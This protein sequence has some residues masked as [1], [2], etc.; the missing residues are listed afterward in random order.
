MPKARLHFEGD[1]T[2]IE[3]EARLYS[4]TQEVEDKLDSI[5]SIETTLQW[6]IDDLQDQI[7]Q[8]ASRGRYLTTWDCTTWLPD[9]NPTTDPYTYR[10]WDYYI[11]GTVGWTNYRPHGSEYHVWVASQTLET[12]AV[13]VNDLY[14]YDWTQWTLQRTWASVYAV[15]WSI[16]WTLS[17]QT[18]LQNALNDKA[19]RTDVLEKTNT[20]SY[21][22]TA[23]YHP[24]TKKY[25]DD[26]D[27]YIW[28]SAPTNNVV[29]W[30]LWY[31]TTADVLKVYDWSQWVPTGKTYTA[32]SHINISNADVISTTGLQDELTAWSNI[33]IQDI[34]VTESDMKWPCPSGFHVPTQ[35]ELSSMVNTLS[36]FSMLSYINTETYY[37]LPPIRYYVNGQ[38]SERRTNNGNYWS[39]VAYGVWSTWNTF[40]NA[41]SLVIS[42]AYWWY[43]GVSDYA[44]YYCNPIRP[45]K[46]TSVAP[47]SNW[48]ILYDWSAIATGAG[49]FHNAAE[50]LISYSSDWTTWY[51]IADK[52]LWATQVWNYWDAMS[53]TNCWWV[54]QRWNNYMFPYGWPASLSATQVDASWY[55]PWNYYYSDTCIFSDLNES[56][57]YT[58]QTRNLWW[59]QTQSTWQDCDLTISATDTTYSA[60]DFDIKDLTDSTGLRT[61]WNSKQDALTAWSHINI[62]SNVISTTGLQDKLTAWDNIQI[63]PRMEPDTKWPCPSWFHV[64]LSTELQTLLDYFTGLGLSWNTDFGTYLKMPIAWFRKYWDS[65]VQGQWSEWRYRAADVYGNWNNYG[66]YMRHNTSGDLYV[67]YSN[68]TSANS[69]RAFKNS[70][71]IP[72]ASWTVLY[73]GSSIAAWAWIFHNATEWLISISSDG[74]NWLTIADKN[75]GATA[76]Y[77]RWDQLSQSN[78][79]CYYQRWNNYWFPFAWGVTTSSTQVDASNYWPW[80]YYSS[81]IFILQSYRWFETANHNLWWWVTQWTFQDGDKISA[82]VPE[83]PNTK[84]FIVDPTVF[85]PDIQDAYDWYAAWNNPILLYRDETYY[86]ESVSSGSPTMMYFR[87]KFISGA[88]SNSSWTQLTWHLIYVEVTNWSVTDVTFST[89]AE[90][91]RKF[92]ATDINYP[93]PYTPQYNGSP[94]TK[95]YVD[96]HWANIPVYYYLGDFNSDITFN[97]IE[98]WVYRIYVRAYHGTT[99]DK[100]LTLTVDWVAVGAL[101]SNLIE[102]LNASINFTASAWSTAVLSVSSK[103]NFT[104]QEVYIEKV[105]IQSGYL[106][107]TVN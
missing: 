50:W 47:D 6:E 91:W 71:V 41:W 65:G 66:Y 57:D 77:N 35:N 46:N 55:W 88:T 45:F 39:S 64:P 42:H 63:E 10:P 84:T 15:W 93:T 61:T 60:S 107:A 3:K 97:I 44:N 78:C 70:V 99:V 34:C 19:N 52:N 76:V 1:N 94:A 102:H 27:T 68:Y 12:Q 51:T 16:T 30:R 43:V 2:W 49:I 79:W 85:L 38:Y 31:D 103:T 13:S 100:T 80:N 92:L 90:V 14:I 37:K 40:K 106:T 24:A 73:D 86:L 96:E 104:I 58:N 101:T 25:T 32:W 69:L 20:T 81:N 5:S 23:D 4:L 26:N 11:V 33:T 22:P 29:E 56:W 95:K 53:Q 83:A 59:W 17:A 105:N 75:V 62:S 21:T 54:F 74:I 89:N 98:A 8:V 9:T 28:T 48:T 82:T 18:D 87:G 67:S 72:D 7:N 36:A